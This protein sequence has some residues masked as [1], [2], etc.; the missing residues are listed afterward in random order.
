MNQTYDIYLGSNKLGTTSFGFT[1]STRGIVFGPICINKNISGYDFLMQWCK[2]NGVELEM[3]L[4]E[5]QIILTKTILPLTIK[6]QKGVTLQWTA[7]QITGIANKDF[8]LSVQGISCSIM[9]QAQSFR[10]IG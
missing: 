1:D 4:P 2:S 10:L 8:E 6:D 3:N 7:N 5:D 9:Y